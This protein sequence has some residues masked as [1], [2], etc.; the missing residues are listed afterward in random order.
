MAL[1]LARTAVRD[2]SAGVGG[3]TSA[4]A[5]ATAIATITVNDSVPAVRAIISGG[6]VQS[7]A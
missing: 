2:R 3:A 1:G 5:A 4:A 6:Y 7:R